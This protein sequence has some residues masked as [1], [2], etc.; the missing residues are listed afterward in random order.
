MTTK[1]ES[2]QL[3]GH[4][5]IGPNAVI[6]IAEALRG[7][8]HMRDLDKLFDHADCREWLKAPPAHMIDETRVAHLH[9]VVRMHYREPESSRLLDDAGTRT[10]DYI[11]AHRVP[12]LLRAILPLLPLGLAVRLLTQAILK[13]AWTFV[14]SGSV[15][16]QI[17][18]S[19]KGWIVELT[20]TANP[21]A[22]HEHSGHAICAWHKGVFTRLYSKLVS[23]NTLA[24]ELFCCAQGR[25]AC[26]FQ[27]EVGYR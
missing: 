24:H 12:A 13:H 27:I 3:G 26:D 9:H 15:H 19:G 4:G 8:G 21:L 16:A 18:E 23:S 10:A 6:Q 17:R 20:I 22:C 2:S 25:S 5:V 11:I 7:G 1:A 14:G